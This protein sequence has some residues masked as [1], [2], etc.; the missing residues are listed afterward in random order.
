MLCRPSVHRDERLRRCVRARSQERGSVTLWFLLTFTALLIIGAFAIDLPRVFTVSGELQNGADAAALAGAG[1][2]SQGNTSGPNWAGAASSA[3]AAVALNTSD[4]VKLTSGS[5]TAG[6]W[7]VAASSPSLLAPG[8]VTLPAPAGQ[9]LEP[10]VQVTISRN[11]TSNGGL[12]HLL[13]GT[14]LGMPT[15][16]DSATAV[17]VIAPPSAVPAGALFPMV[18]DQCVYNQYWDSTKNAPKLDAAGQPYEFQVGNGQEYGASCEAGQWTSFLVV[19]N[20]TPT[21]VNLIDN[22]NPTSLSIG[23]SIY[24]EPGVKAAVYKS[25]P[26]ATTVLMPVSTQ[27]ENKT[28][29]PIIAFAAFHI[30]SADQGSKYIQGHFVAGYTMPTQGTGVSTKNYGGYVAPRLAF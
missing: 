9:L 24:I 20:D 13:L 8:K 27:I 11:A 1:A 19:A 28:L 3:T 30:D 26:T 16:A 14:L 22:G 6:Y 18:M 21:V 23:D 25:I 5:V 2:L 7:D 29:V 12:V 17:A 10:A 4:G 15:T